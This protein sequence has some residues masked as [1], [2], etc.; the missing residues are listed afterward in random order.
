M[1]DRTVTPL[2][3]ACIHSLTHAIQNRIHLMQWWLS[4]VA[5]L[6]VTARQ[7]VL[8]E[9]SGV[10][11]AQLAG[12]H[13][14]ASDLAI[15]KS[16]HPDLFRSILFD[17]LMPIHK[18]L[19]SL[20]KWEEALQL[21][22]AIYSYYIKQDE[23]WDFYELAFSHLYTP[24]QQLGECR[25][26]AP[27]PPGSI[28]HVDK[29]LDHL[30]L[31]KQPEERTLFWFQNYSILAHSTVCLE[32]V[33]S[34]KKSEG[35][36]ASA[37]NNVNLEKSRG[38]FSALGI[39]ILALDNQL[40][41]SGRCRQL[42]E[43]CRHHRIQNIVFVSLPLQSGYLNTIAGEIRLTWW[44]MKYPLG[45]M[46]HFDRLVCNRSITPELRPINGALWHCAPFA[47]KALPINP[48][49]LNSIQPENMLRLGVL[50]REEK[51]AASG[52]PEIMSRSLA[53]TPTA[54]LYWTGRQRNSSLDNRLHGAAPTELKGRIEFCGWVDPSRFLT[55]V[56]VLVDT[57]NLG[58]LVAYW[59]M[60][61]GKVVLSA[62][63][64]G[65]IGALG[66][67]ETLSHYFHYLRS[68]SE[69]DDYFSSPSDRPFYLASID[70]IPL[71]VEKYSRNRDLL[72]DHGARFLSVFNRHLSDMERWSKLTFQMLQGRGSN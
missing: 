64:S 50:A 54:N 56:D 69:V 5:S 52:L 68:E 33:E 57:P 36:Y 39:E 3:L 42:V 31:D 10:V 26:I 37:L 38:I 24:Y 27:L 67:R 2:T 63:D 1:N 30:P 21:E 20:Q 11:A 48:D 9:L 49:I 15:D 43:L 6:Q 23:D 61:M 53:A 13:Q 45:C 25:Q 19:V 14:F 29:D 58:G 16:Q 62:T 40:D 34:L 55:M 35:F 41:Y 44:S 8:T 4:S 28:T 65:S 17:F 66:S 60:S 59:M 47:L 46:R 12:I 32:F 7:T 70:L 71:C 72:S 22:S 18:H 51:F